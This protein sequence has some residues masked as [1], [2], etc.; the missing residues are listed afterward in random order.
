MFIYVLKWF[1]YVY[2]YFYNEIIILKYILNF[3]KYKKE[4]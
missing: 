4:I 1:V 3:I 2:F